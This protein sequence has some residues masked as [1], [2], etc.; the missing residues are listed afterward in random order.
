MQHKLV[1]W[2]GWIAQWCAS[3]WYHGKK[4]E[5]IY[6]DIWKILKNTEKYIKKYIE[7]L[8]NKKTLLH[9]DCYIYHYLM[10]FVIIIYY[11]VV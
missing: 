7:K 6:I 10:L 1:N 5:Y 2:E 9:I 11:F 3:L 4:L 8:M